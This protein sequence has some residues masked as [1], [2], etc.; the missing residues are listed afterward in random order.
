MEQLLQ[1]IFDSVITPIFGEIPA[2]AETYVKAG[3]MLLLALLMGLLIRQLVFVR[4]KK[5]TE[6]TANFYDDIIL[7]TLR[8]KTV[9]W[10]IL[11]ATILTIPTLHWE[12][13]YRRLAEQ[14]T[15]AVLILSITIAIVR[16]VSEAITKYSEHSGAGV[17][18]STLIRYVVSFV[19]YALGLA[20]ILSLFNVSLLPAITA[21]GVG[22]LAVALAFQ[23]TLANLFAGIHMTLSQ[24]LHL[25]DYVQLQSGEEG[26]V[27][28]ISWRTTTLRTLAN[29]LIIIPNKKLSESIIINFNLPM[30]ELAIELNVGVS[31]DTDPAYV[32]EVLIDIVKGAYGEVEGVLDE[33]P[34]IRFHAFAD[35]SLTMRAFVKVDKVENRFAARHELM[36]RVYKRFREEGIEIPFP[37]RTLQFKSEG[38][39]DGIVGNVNIY[40]AA[41]GGKKKKKKSLSEG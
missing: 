40:E 24:Q 25:E 14:L 29:N 33:V 10:V 11:I 7:E 2:T 16:G 23:D 13:Q 17:G 1:T 9:L 27:H 8:R 31:Y 39:F 30:S 3:M 26:F 5:Y 6:K 21:L 15:M 22:G 35:S 34:A 4:V 20:V 12:E 41:E 36:K 19:F 18:G 38:G 28:D 37:I 32:E